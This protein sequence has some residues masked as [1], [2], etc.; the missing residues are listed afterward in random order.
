MAF[1]PRVTLLPSGHA[2]DAA[3]PSRLDGRFADLVPSHR[4]DAILLDRQRVHITT[5]TA[6]AREYS[7][8]S[9]VVLGDPDG[10]DEG[11]AGPRAGH[12][13][14]YGLGVGVPQASL[15]L[16]EAGLG[17]P[18]EAG[19]G[20]VSVDVVMLQGQGAVHASR[21]AAHGVLDLGAGGAGEGGA[22]EAR[23][24]DAGVASPALELPR[25]AVV[26]GTLG[27]GGGGGDAVEAHGVAG[28]GG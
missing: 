8:R 28:V 13:G 5:A 3:L 9:D 19:L 17:V 15:L 1:V 24:R 16:R 4:L 6:V 26:V 7:T 2:D 14:S 27:G 18:S 25:V 22:L 23:R 21:V 12:L 10:L 20:S 11:G